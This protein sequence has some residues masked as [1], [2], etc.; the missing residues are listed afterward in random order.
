MRTIN[1]EIEQLEKKIGYTFN[2][3]ELLCQA[4]THSSYANELKINYIKDYE[5]I[6][7]L[8]DAILEFVSSDFLYRKYAGK[9][10]GELTKIRAK[11][12]CES[13]LAYCAR[14]L[15]VGK[16]LR[17]GKG[18]RLGGGTDRDSILA[19]CVEAII[20]AIYLDSDIVSARKF[21]LDNVLIDIEDRELFI[22]CKSSLQ[23]M[24][25]S[26]GITNIEYST[27]K[28]EGPEH[29]KYYYVDVLVDGNICGSG[30]GKS[31][32]NAEQDAAKKAIMLLKKN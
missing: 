15:D 10:E 26:R 27:T 31:K 18:E 22:D 32:K 4:L 29:N 2:E 30:V 28:E 24:V 19:D 16:Y 6:E 3:K 5:R 12:V 20:G 11:L 14:K 23:E 13:S 21:I 17:L 9:K 25:Q 7:Y 1:F 8:G